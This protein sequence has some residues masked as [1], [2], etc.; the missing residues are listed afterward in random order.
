[1]D[2]GEGAGR[3][4]HTL[5]D[6]Q[7]AACR[8]GVRQR[9]GPA[10]PAGSAVTAR[11][12]TSPAVQVRF[13]NACLK[14]RENVDGP[15]TSEW[16]RLAVIHGGMPPLSERTHPE[17]CAHRRAFS[18]VLFFPLHWILV[19][20]STKLADCAPLPDLLIAPTGAPFNPLPPP[21]HDLILVSIMNTELAANM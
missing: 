13:A 5:R 6:S 19:C 21:P 10:S 18:V 16:F 7:H 15:G 3:S 4:C 12:A 2:A 14:L 9:R 20:T 1:M 11:S 8:S 17:Y